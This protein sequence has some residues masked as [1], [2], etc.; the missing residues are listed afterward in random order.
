MSLD[1]SLGTARSGI[2]LISR[3]LSQAAANVANAG[4]EGYTS[5]RI[6]ARAMTAAGMPFGVRSLA[7]DRLVDGALVARMLSARSADAAASAREASLERIEQA[8]GTIAGEQ[9]VADLT[10]RLHEGL[11]AL[12]GAPSDPIRHRAIVIGAED[13]VGRFHSVSDAIGAVRQDAQDGMATEVRAINASLRDIA[14]LTDEIRPERLAGRTVADLEDQRDAAIARL[15]ESIDVTVLRS[16]DGGI[17]LM[18]RGGVTLPLDRDRDALSIA[19]ATVGVGSYYGL[20]AGTLP[21]VVLMGTDVTAN[22]TGGRL[23][24]YRN[25]RDGTLPR[26]QAELDVLATGIAARFEA[27]GLRLFTTQAG[28]VPNPTLPYTVSGAMGFA[29]SI[30]V[31]AAVLANPALVR[32]GTHAV[33]GFV[34]N[35]PGGPAGF[36]V[37][38]E[39]VLRFTLG[40][41]QAPGVPHP[42]FASAGLGPDGSLLARVASQPSLGA[43]ATQL[44]AVQT[45]ERAEAA[46]AA[47]AASTLRTG[48]EGRF[49][50]MSG[51]DVD[52]EMA[53]MVMLQNSYAANARVM[54]A[55]QQMFEQLL[56]AVR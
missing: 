52:Q 6:E 21:G 30:R 1:V 23:G 19:P 13:L 42:A 15:A 35:P 41:E 20:P 47:E 10:A 17:V 49:S 27:Q 11:I 34:P 3:Q 53:A 22:L 24:E 14:R 43:Q 38:I 33:P 26:M 36:A 44:V 16:A 48:L 5:K 40:A 45:M 39:R 32:D 50:R 4:T 18:T 28:T 55:V 37:L 56:G 8:H 12:Q 31:S 25:L 51:V 2:A 46:Q 7:A 29:S 54:S 9:S